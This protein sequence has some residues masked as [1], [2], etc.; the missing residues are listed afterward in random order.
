MKVYQMFVPILLIMAICTEPHLARG[1]VTKIENQG[2]YH[3][4]HPCSKEISTGWNNHSA[5]WQI[6]LGLSTKSPPNVGNI[7]AGEGNQILQTGGW[8][9]DAVHSIFCG[10]ILLKHDGTQPDT[11]EWH[12]L[13]N[14]TFTGGSGPVIGDLNNDH[15]PEVISMIGTKYLYALNMKGEPLPAFP[16]FY[17]SVGSS[18]FGQTI[19]LAD[20]DDDGHLDIIVPYARKYMGNSVWNESAIFALNSEN[21]VLDGW[22]HIFYDETTC[23]VL[24]ACDVDNDGSN[25]VV[26]LTI[27]GSG[28]AATGKIYVFESDGTIMQNWPKETYSW[29]MF[30]AF[31]DIDDDGDLEIFVSSLDMCL[32]A[33]H[34]DGSV[35][36]NWHTYCDQ[37]LWGAPVVGDIDGDTDPE[38]IV[39]GSNKFYAFHHDGSPVK[40]W[41]LYGENYANQFPL[42]VDVDSDG[43]GEIFLAFNNKMYCYTQLNDR[44]VIYD[45][46]YPLEVDSRILAA[47]AISDFDLDGKMDLLLST[48]K[49]FMY[50][51]NLSHPFKERALHWS[52]YMHDQVHSGSFH[53]NNSTNNPPEIISPESATAYEGLPF[54][55]TAKAVDPDDDEIAFF[56]ESYPG[57]LSPEDSMISG[58]P[59][60]DAPDASFIVIASDG[61]LM[62]TLSVH[63]TVDAATKT[64]K[65]VFA[66]GWNM[67]SLNVIPPHPDVTEV[68]F[69]LVDKLVLLKNSTGESYIPAYGINTIVDVDFRAGYQ[70]FLT[71][72]ANLDVTGQA[73][74][75]TTPIALPGGWS[76]VAYLPDMPIDAAIALASLGSQLKIAKNYAG[77]AYIPDFGINTIGNMQ[78]GQGYQVYLS[79]ADTLRYPAA[80]ILNAQRASA[81]QRTSKPVEH[82]QFRAFT[83]ENATVVVP[84]D[85]LPRYSDDS[86]LAIGDEIGAFTPNGL[87]C[88]AIVWEN[89]NAAITMWGDDSETDTLDGFKGGDSLHFRVWRQ[90][91][92]TEYAARVGFQADQSALYQP[93]GFAV[94]TELIADLSTDVG[95]M[96]DAIIPLQFRLFQN[97]PNP[98]NPETE[99]AFELPL[100]AEVRLTVFDLRGQV[101]RRLLDAITPAGCHRVLWNGRDESGRPIASGTYFY[102]LQVREID[103]ERV[104]CTAIKKMILMK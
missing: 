39:A 23:H 77:A 7:L 95:E 60:Y 45:E 40:G 79:D 35:V 4:M 89:T 47:P 63:L 54:T 97:Y 52:M 1:Q 57:W 88:G 98:F 24:A 51:F 31:A 8:Y 34:H 102:R 36:A 59:P 46:S 67:V 27:K 84:A 70:A 21:K 69:G 14:A 11:S 33:F 44:P 29:T 20:M 5:D 103:S 18:T 10:V 86:P 26:A 62:D 104:S 76:M 48:E 12:F 19:S 68:F 81:G 99:I 49:D 100:A 80:G 13:T 50:L 38:I 25:E 65:L 96:R 22:P 9:D 92:G 93:N 61:E 41:P 58:T 75:P 87:C 71:G 32:Y 17:E 15:L 42:I 56:F 85:I 30:P 16:Y 72:A 91:S 78:A 28:S 55:Y 101:V 37:M 83:G 74:N 43:S 94:L 73:V 53:Y 3:Q 90:S 6:N 2:Y 66:L 82:F 64:T